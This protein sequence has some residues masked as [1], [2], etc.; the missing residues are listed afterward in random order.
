MKMLLFVPVLFLLL[1]GSL[2]AQDEDEVM[3][4]GDANQSGVV[5]MSDAILILDYLYGNPPANID[6]LDSADSND[7]GFVEDA[8]FVH[9]T[10]WLFHGGPI[11]PDPGPYYCGEDPT[12]D[13]L[14]CVSYDCS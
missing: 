13:N 6:C 7:D 10:N 11:P 4:R 8:D 1:S 14:S 5:D 3:L 2:S 12:S 9:L